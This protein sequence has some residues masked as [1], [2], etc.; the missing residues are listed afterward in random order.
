MPPGSSLNLLPPPP[1]PP[2]LCLTDRGCGRERRAERN[3]TKRTR[4]PVGTVTGP[5]RNAALGAHLLE[6]VG[7]VCASRAVT[8]A[9]VCRGFPLQWGEAHGDTGVT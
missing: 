5:G 3:S 2:M 4:C 6:H 1:T 9:A 7:R 8:K